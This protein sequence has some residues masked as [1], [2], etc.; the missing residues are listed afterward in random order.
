M[1]A[2]NPSHE[3]TPY[4]TVQEAADLLHVDHKVIYRLVREQRLRCI[5]L[6]NGPKAAIRIPIAAIDELEEQSRTA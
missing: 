4:L 2:R 5:R 3:R 1:V 6:G